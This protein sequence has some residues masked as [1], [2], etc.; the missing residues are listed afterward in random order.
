[1]NSPSLTLGS[2]FDGSGG[3]PLAGKLAGI[4]P[5][6]ASEIE[7][8]PI[9]VTTKRLPEM[10]HL[11]DISKLDGGKIP[12]VDIITFGSPCTDLSVA[13]RRAGLTGSQSGLFFEAVRV[14]KEMRCATNEKYPR[15]LVWENVPGSLSS[16]QGRDF[17]TVLESLLQIKDKAVSVPMPEKWT[18]A[19]EIL[20]ETCS[21]AWRILDAQFWGV[22]QRRRRVFLVADFG[23]GCAGKILFESEGVS[24]NPAP[25]EGTGQGTAGAADGG[26]DPAIGFEPGAMSRLGG[27]FQAEQVST[28]RADMGDNQACVAVSSHPQDCRVDI[29]KS[30]SVQTLTGQMG[31]GGGNVPMILEK[32]QEDNGL[33]CNVREKGMSSMTGTAFTPTATDYKDPQCAAQAYGIGSYDSAGMMSDNPQAGIYPADTS[34]TLDQGGG[35]PACSQGG[36]AIV[37]KASLACDCRNHRCRAEVSGTLQAKSSGDQSLNYIN[38]V[39][40]PKERQYSVR[41]LTPLECCRLQGFPDWWCSGLGTEAPAEEELSFWR[42]VFETH[43][44]ITGTSSK[45]K[46]EKQ[47]LKWLQNPYSDSAEYKMWGNGVALPCVY[48]V[49]N[50]IA[51]AV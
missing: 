9:R 34:R 50:G 7:P 35:N 8:F 43:R 21:L 15:F 46:T 40:V 36:I 30:G 18:G 27:H 33:I 39:A 16:H 25:V 37:Q 10:T 2:L 4:R 48:Y 47:L 32:G 23:G 1:M 22:A 49:L 19:G 3:F 45:P 44:K 51:A 38:P 42:D 24:G 6:W 20:G 12:P 31:T 5:V 14:I 28:L 41:R 29:D 17:R 26:T 13:G 11:G